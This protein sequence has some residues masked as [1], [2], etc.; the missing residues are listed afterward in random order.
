MDKTKTLAT[1]NIERDI[2]DEFKA[3]CASSHKTATQELLSFVLGYIG[4]SEPIQTD[5][6]KRI[7]IDD[8]IKTYLEANL[9]ELVS[10]MVD[11]KVGLL[12]EK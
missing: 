6:G 12:L 8:A 10:K 11:E 4:R 5:T 2:W 1:F 7:N 9:D 3:K